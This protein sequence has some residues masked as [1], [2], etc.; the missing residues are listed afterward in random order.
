MNADNPRSHRRIKRWGDRYD[1]YG[2]AVAVLLAGV[3][4]AV[5]PSAWPIWVGLALG[6]ANITSYVFR[7]RAANR[8]DQADRT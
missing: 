1:A 5:E 8:T 6:V 7:K 2:L 4:L 3:A